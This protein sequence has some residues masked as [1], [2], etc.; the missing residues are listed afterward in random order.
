MASARTEL[1][2]HPASGTNGPRRTA[3]ELT[4]GDSSGSRIA[5]Q[6]SR[7]VLASSRRLSK[8]GGL[9]FTVSVSLL[10]VLLD[11]CAVNLVR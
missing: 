9:V 3:Y 7:E 5:A 10:S 2:A 4:I 1:T 11:L 8:K 6:P